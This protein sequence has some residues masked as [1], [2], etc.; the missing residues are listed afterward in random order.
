MV[1]M[2][3]AERAGDVPVAEKIAL[4]GEP[5]FVLGR[6]TIAPARRELVRDDGTREV[7]EHRVM[8]VLIALARADG[9]VVTR[10]ELTQSCWDGRIVGE[11]A[12]NRVISRLRKTADGI[13]TGSFRIE[14]VTKIGYRLV[15]PDAES[16]SAVGRP[17]RTTRRAFAIGA[18][19]AGLLTAAG[20]GTLAWRRLARPERSP[21]VESLF[22]Q[23][24]QAWT[25][26]TS[27]G[28]N[29]AIGLYRRAVEIAPGDADA[30]GYLACAYSDRAQYW[31]TAA[32][33]PILRD[34]TQVAGQRALAIDPENALARA[35]I[36]HAR[37]IRGN[38]LFIERGY[39][40]A[41]ADEPDQHLVI[42][43][44][45]LLLTFV[46]RN[47]EA[48]DGFARLRDAAPIVNRYRFHI[49]ALWSA[50][51]LDE[52]ENLLEEAGAIYG[53]QSNIWFTRFDMLL[54]GGRPGAAIALAM[55]ER[56][57]PEGMTAQDIEGPLA[58]ARALLSGDPADADSIMT[59][60]IAQVRATGRNAVQTIESASA[61]GRL[62]DAFMLAE[63]YY[64]SRGFVTPDGGASGTRP[65]AANLE[66]RSTRFLFQPAT[67]AM[68]ADPRFAGLMEELGLE[69]YWRACGALP[70][71]RRA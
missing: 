35:A 39:R 36:A 26:G 55:D 30:W 4:A 2:T 7:V 66:A 29:Q 70:D 28:N 13:G 44:L 63:A 62:D 32:E 67:T 58:V 42:H 61:L 20:A 12:I 17:P 6:L 68:R 18:V 15:R 49:R 47:S 40:D 64:F 51:R 57:R 54:Y 3:P 52:A 45:A 1:W 38:W 60:G 53:T 9:A 37:P 16:G 23:A 56:A 33:A 21:E 34:R 27:E 22:A 25:Q 46:G 24:W 11:D 14:T 50:G 41:L 48:A 65:P 31:A 19:A 59:S 10:D 5:D 43:C 71:Y 8:Q 69:R